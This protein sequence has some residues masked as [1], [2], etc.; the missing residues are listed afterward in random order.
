MSSVVMRR[1][2]RKDAQLA[3]AAPKLA[4]LTEGDKRA[5]QGRA[6]TGMRPKCPPSPGRP[7]VAR[8]DLESEYAFL[9]IKGG[10]EELRRYLAAGRVVP[11]I[12][13][14]V[15]DAEGSSDDGIRQEF[16]VSVEALEVGQPRKRGKGSYE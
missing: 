16:D 4:R 11:V 14:G 15:I 1:D 3:K 9:D 6:D 5:R 13:R 12:I 7:K 10:R 2:T 8:L